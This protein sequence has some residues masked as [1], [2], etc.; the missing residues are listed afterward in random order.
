[1]QMAYDDDHADDDDAGDDH[2]VRSHCQS[3]AVILI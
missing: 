2:D 1:M 3:K